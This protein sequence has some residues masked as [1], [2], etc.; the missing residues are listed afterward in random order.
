MRS[1]AQFCRAESLQLS[2]VSTIGKKLVKQQYLPHMFPQ[3]GPLTAEIGLGVWGIP[4]NFNGFRILAL[5]LQRRQSTEANQTFHNVWPLPGLVGYI[6]I[7]GSCCSVMEFCQVQNSLCVLQVLRC[8]IGSIT[9]WQSISGYKPSF[10]ALS[11]GRH[12]YSAGRPSC[13]AL[14]H[15]LVC[16]CDLVVI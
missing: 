6:C 15:I 14:A 2:H 8:P 5:L 10:A 1:T 9:A 7:F 12:L 4:A 13:W 16:D 11:T 3:Y